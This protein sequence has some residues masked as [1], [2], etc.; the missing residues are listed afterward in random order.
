MSLLVI[1]AN[2]FIGQAFV[3]QRQGGEI[4]TARRMISGEFVQF[5]PLTDELQTLNGI[6]AISHALILFA[7]R[8]PDRCI[9]DPIGTARVNVE[10]PCRIVDQC[11]ALGITPVLAS[12]ELVFDGKSGMYVESALP[13]PILEYGRQKLATER[14]LLSSRAEGLILRFP[15][16]VGL[17]RHD[18]SL[19]TTWIDKILQ[20]PKELTCAADQYFSLQLVDDVPAIVRSLAGHGMRGI[21]HVGD[22]R[23][24]SRFDLLSQLCSTLKAIDIDT[25]ELKKVSIHDFNL[26]EPRPLDVSM[27]SSV[28]TSLTGIYAEPI[29]ELILRVSK[30]YCGT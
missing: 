21:V 9:K 23:R 4:Y 22:G 2:G 25:P 14:Y 17:Q 12:T 29:E 15:K 13:E 19:F 7:E 28:L 1:G 6:S 10:L 20:G 3:R 18:H 26:P 27:N 30:E 5:D 16:T 24:H 11:F 8:E